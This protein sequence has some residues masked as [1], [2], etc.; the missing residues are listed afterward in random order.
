MI[1]KCTLCVA[2]LLSCLIVAAA[3]A[4]AQEN[5]PR[6]RGAD[7]SGVVADDSRLPDTWDQT[8]NVEWK[9][10]IP[11]S[12]WGSP[13][14]WGDRVFVSAVHS[15]DD[16]EKP[17]GGLYLGGG[18]GEPPDSVHHWM[19]YCLS[20]KTGE[21]LW[22]HEAHTGKPQIPRAHG[23]ISRLRGHMRGL[24]QRCGPREPARRMPF[25]GRR[26]TPEKRARPTD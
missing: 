6:F 1:Q 17:K 10:T 24:R 18:R 26:E 3:S 13:I 22:K 25:P 16:Y 12:G 8:T 19:V 5:W 23:R 14:V 21:V 9:V 2:L 7:A 11:G 4:L 15:D 20:L